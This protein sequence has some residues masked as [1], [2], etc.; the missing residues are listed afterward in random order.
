MYNKWKNY[1][2]GKK[3]KTKQKTTGKPYLQDLNKATSETTT[4]F[5]G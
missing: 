3:K 1:E 5:H 4:D 2:A